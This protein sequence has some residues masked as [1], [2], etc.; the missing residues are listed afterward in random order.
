MTLEDV[1]APPGEA[2][3]PRPRARRAPWAVPASVVAGLVALAAVGAGFVRLP[4]V[5]ISPGDAR[6]VDRVVRIEGA[7]TY[8]HDGSVLFLTVSVTDPDNPPN[9]Y[10]VLDGWLDDDV[11]V[12]SEDELL[13][14]RTPEQEERLNDVAMA[15]SQL[16]AKKVS[17]E[18]LGHTVPVS[19]GGAV[20]TSVVKQSP[21]AGKLEVGDVI[22]AVD[23]MPVELAEELGL[24]VR[25]RPAGEPVTFTVRRD[26][27]ARTVTVE[28]RAAREGPFEG[29]A[30]VGVS[31][32]TKDLEFDFPVD[33]TIDTGDVGGPSAG[34]AFTL[35]ILDE[36]SPGDLTGGKEIAVTG[37]IELDGSVGPVGGVAQK[38][39]TARGA[40][41]RLFI[42]PE[43]EEKEAREHASGM[44]VAGVRNL[45]D[46]LAALQQVGGDPV[47]APNAAAAP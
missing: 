26:R 19:G 24:A 39:V 40:G 30:Q 32:S 18:R 46:V 3:L 22:T 1:E 11:Q 23:G 14:G 43:A 36:L 21:A 6:P 38:A 12:I 16:V 8:E 31:S 34:L 20:V 37:T 44:K 10:G 28:T 7:P 42:V 17:L 2:P 41:A 15:S 4:Y 25:A 35:T 47:P 5:L 13:Q 29:E 27:R 9:M 45:D 33:V